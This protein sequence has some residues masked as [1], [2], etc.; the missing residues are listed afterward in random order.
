V[1]DRRRV[2]GTIRA[3]FMDNGATHLESYSWG[4]RLPSNARWA[5][6]SCMVFALINCALRRRFAADRTSRS[7]RLAGVMSVLGSLHYIHKRTAL[8][9]ADMLIDQHSRRTGC[10]R[11]PRWWSCVTRSS[12]RF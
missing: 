9:E 6:I 4:S 3:A 11:L 5:P 10:G 1:S 8:D 7:T 12:S 2:R